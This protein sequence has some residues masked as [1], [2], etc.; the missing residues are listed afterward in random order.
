MLAWTPAGAV[1][2]PRTLQIRL[3]R[4]HPDRVPAGAP[5]PS[6]SL[7]TE[8][9]A[10]NLRW[11]TAASTRGLPVDALVLS[12]HGVPA[13][14]DL[15]EVLALARALGVVRVVLHVGLEDLAGLEPIA[16]VDRYVLP[17]RLGP[18]GADPAALISALEGARRAGVPIDAN[19][20]LMTTA[21][22]FAAAAA[23]LARDA[24]AG[25]VTFTYPFP[26]GGPAL[27]GQ[28]PPPVP[29]A[30]AA[31]AAALPE[32]EG[33]VP[34]VSVKGLPAC[35]IP[36]H[37]RL[38]RKSQNRW[39]VDADHQKEAALLFFP[40]VVAFS[41]GDVCRFCAADGAC[42]GSFPAWAGR[43]GNPPLRPF[44]P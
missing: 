10:A 6:R 44:E 12:G 27:E 38:V 22:P 28:G 37:A 26:P 15:P 9:V 1:P 23:A 11:F 34:S 41:K 13:R 17:V 19:I 25:S 21:L 8:E 4:A 29:D 14:A 16:G 42:D 35:W 24:A 2:R 7:T 36:A 18:D 5:P 43:P 39:Y 3:H 20:P 31:L 33:R 40:G 32:V 30:V